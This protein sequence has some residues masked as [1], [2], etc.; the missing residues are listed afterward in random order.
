MVA[1]HGRQRM[2]AVKVVQENVAEEAQ[3]NGQW[4][5]RRPGRSRMFKPAQI[6]FDASVLDCVLLD[7]SP[8]GA[9][10]CFKATMDVPDLVTLRLPNGESRSM[11][12]CWQRGA[13]MG[14]EF[15]GTTPLVF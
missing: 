5:E 8:N 13:H 2:E 12:R 7:A 6:A 10:V 11:R 4:R 3:G 1:E 9:Q 15:V 14:F